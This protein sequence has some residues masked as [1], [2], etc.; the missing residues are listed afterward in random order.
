MVCS[1]V[2]FSSAF[3]SVRFLPRSP[4]SKFSLNSE[5]LRAKQ[6]SSNEEFTK[7]FRATGDK[8]SLKEKVYLLAARTAR[9]ARATKAEKDE[10]ET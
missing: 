9:G 3:Q 4:L 7:M 8:A 5:T 10:A 1:L 6:I 2:L